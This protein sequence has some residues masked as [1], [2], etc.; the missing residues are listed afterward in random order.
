MSKTDPFPA[1]YQQVPT[2]LKY[3][4]MVDA[5]RAIGMKPAA[6]GNH[7]P[8]DLLQLC[9]DFDKEADAIE[10]R[11]NPVVMLSR[12]N[13]EGLRLTPQ[14]DGSFRFLGFR[15]VV[16]EMLPR[17]TVV[18]MESKG[19]FV[20]LPALRP[21]DFGIDLKDSVMRT[22]MMVPYFIDPLP[23]YSVGYRPH[24]RTRKERRRWMLHCWRKD[25]RRIR[26][27][28]PT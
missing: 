9:R 23:F 6:Q 20:P 18:L 13:I 14:P 24:M 12:K 11:A 5:A 15:V 21:Q 7:S 3:D 22:A 16:N 28:R 26:S 10:A 27:Q 2:P 8:S 17:D 1:E 4:E 25:A 19:A